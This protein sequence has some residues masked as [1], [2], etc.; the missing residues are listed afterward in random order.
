[1]IEDM[2]HPGKLLKERF[3]DP[4]GVTSYALAKGLGVHQTR[5]SQI[6]GGKRSLTVDTAVRLGAYFGVPARWFLEMQMR[7]DLE[8]A[9]A[10][11]AKESVQPYHDPRVLVLP[12]GVLLVE[13]KQA[14]VGPTMHEISEELVGRLEAQA[15]LA[16]PRQRHEVEEVRYPNGMRGLVAVTR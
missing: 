10:K 2:D 7:Y 15:A 6:I 8:H 3:L 1:M 16:P 11:G 9:V 12:S 5:I 14:H 13:A 4:I